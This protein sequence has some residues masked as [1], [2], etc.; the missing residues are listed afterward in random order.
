MMVLGLL[1][2]TISSASFA[3]SPYLFGKV[4]DYSLPNRTNW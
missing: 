1:C 2:L 4:I 3:L